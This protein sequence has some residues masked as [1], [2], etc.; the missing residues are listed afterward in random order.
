[1][2]LHLEMQIPLP[3]VEKK[4]EVL[5]DVNKDRRYTIDASLV[6]IMKSQKTLAYQQLV[7]E[8]EELLNRRFKVKWY[9]PRHFKWSVCVCVRACVGTR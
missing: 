7:M 4:K 2:Y 6:R 8:C 3:L 1:M 9:P 5:E